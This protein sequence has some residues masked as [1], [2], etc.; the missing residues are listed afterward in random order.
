MSVLRWAVADADRMARRLA[1]LRRCGAWV[2]KAVVRPGFTEPERRAQR[3]V[4]REAVQAGLH[5][6]VDAAGNLLV[7]RA[8]AGEVGGRGSLAAGRD[9][10]GG[11]SRAA[12]QRAG[13]GDVAGGRGSVLA[14]QRAG[15]GAAS[16]VRPRLILGAHLD[17]P[18]G[19]DRF[20]GAH[21]VVAALE[22]LQVVAESAGDRELACEPVVVVFANSAGAL[23]PHP[24]WGANAVLGSVEREPADRFGTSLRYPLHQAGGDLDALDSAAW[25]S[26][27]MAWLGVE[28][29]RCGELDGSADLGIVAGFQGCASFEIGA[30]VRG[31]SVDVAVSE[32]L[33]AVA[34][35]GHGSVTL[36][37]LIL[38]SDE[39]LALVE[40]CDPSPATLAAVKDMERQIGSPVAVRRVLTADPADADFA[41]AKLLAEAADV[42]SLRHTAVT[43]RAGGDAQLFA[44]TVPTGALLV[45]ATGDRVA[46]SCLTAAVEVLLQVTRTLVGLR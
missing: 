42:Q 5:A 19:G 21:G 41:L 29:D 8:G 6:W 28:V 37:R 2:D 3:Y 45:P 9:A 30:G 1:A 20:G 4:A 12:G 11:G 40:L 14:E 7:G 34:A 43:T 22:V 36:G 10:S 33:A 26:P 15:V 18:P 35:A 38:P 16:W 46:G 27:A 31:G 23:F 32:S 39:V 24:G 44:P 17:T 13:A 25:P